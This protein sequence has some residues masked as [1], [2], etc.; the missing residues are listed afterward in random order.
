MH[1]A[2]RPTGNHS[3]RTDV[4]PAPPPRAA[5]LGAEGTHTPAHRARPYRAQWGAAGIAS[6]CFIRRADAALRAAPRTPSASSAASDLHATVETPTSK[7]HPSTAVGRS[8]RGRNPKF[9]DD[10][11]ALIFIFRCVLVTASVHGNK[12]GR[13]D[14]ALCVE[15]SGRADAAL[16]AAPRAPSSYAGGKPQGQMSTSKDHPS[17]SCRPLAAGPKS[18]NSGR[19]MGASLVWGRGKMT[20]GLH[21]NVRAWDGEFCAKKRRGRTMRGGCAARSSARVLPC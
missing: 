3:A 20:A 5:R 6:G 17:F 8:P 1:P 21:A 13:Q 14:G 10:A 12:R 19:R 15:I 7:D 18:E 16:R 9:L 11:W 2:G 4:P